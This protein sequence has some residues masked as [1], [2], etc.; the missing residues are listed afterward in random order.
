MAIAVVVSDEN[1]DGKVTPEIEPTD[2]VTLDTEPAATSAAT[3]AADGGA[4]YPEV[5]SLDKMSASIDAPDGVPR[6]ANESPV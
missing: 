6:R 4:V 1:P 5:A 3:E 2:P